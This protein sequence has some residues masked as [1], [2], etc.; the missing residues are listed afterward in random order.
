MRQTF[1]DYNETCELMDVS[2]AI[3]PPSLGMLMLRGISNNGPFGQAKQCVINAL[4]TNYLMSADEVMANILQL[5]Q[6]MDDDLPES[7]LTN[8][9]GPAPPISAFVAA[10]RKS[11][12]GRGH[13]PVAVAAAVADPPSAALVAS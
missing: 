3:N 4:D 5:A 1:V 10:R 7:T 8:P 9:L 13:K 11:H 12:G 6:N 2:A